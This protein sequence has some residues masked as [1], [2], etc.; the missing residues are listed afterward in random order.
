M[1]MPKRLC[2]LF[3]CMAV[4]LFFNGCSNSYDRNAFHILDLSYDEQEGIYAFVNGNLFF[5]TI[6]DDVC[7]LKQRTPKGEIV[8]NGSVKQIV[9]RT[10]RAFDSPY[11]YMYRGITDDTSANYTN[12]N[13][14]V[15][16]INILDHSMKLYKHPEAQAQGLQTYVFNHEVVTV[17]SYPEGNL[18]VSFIESFDPKTETWKKHLKSTYDSVSVTGAEIHEICPG[19]DNLFVLVDEWESPESHQTKLKILDK[20]YE[21]VKT[22]NISEELYKWML[23]YILTG[24]QFYNGYLYIASPGQGLLFQIRDDDLN[25]VHKD[26]DFRS[27][28]VA[29]DSEP[30]FYKSYSNIIYTIDEAGNLKEYKLSIKNGFVITNIIADNNECCVL[31]KNLENRRISACIIGKDLFID[32]DY[33]FDPGP[34]TKQPFSEEIRG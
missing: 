28:T 10:T 2:F 22:Y 14:A 23:S 25:L 6:E 32:A 5:E 17:R 24:M 11:L 3:L 1:S 18:S 29:S 19:G 15:A 12:S 26:Y 30:L 8:E 13:E 9:S 16:A 4:L 27:A 20:N 34:G 33:I 31:F 21:L 7:V